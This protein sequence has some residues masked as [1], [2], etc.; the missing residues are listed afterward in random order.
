MR[1]RIAIVISSWI[2]LL[3]PT[4]FASAD[5]ADELID[6][7]RSAAQADGGVG[8]EPLA[9]RANKVKGSHSVRMNVKMRDGECIIAVAA[10]PDTISDAQLSIRGAQGLWIDDNEPG[11]VAKIHYCASSDERIQFR[12]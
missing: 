5:T 12:A 1:T 4:A 6:R 7:A 2:A 8:R 11:N 3:L 9:M 10:G